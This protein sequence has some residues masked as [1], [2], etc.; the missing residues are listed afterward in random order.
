M[1]LGAKAFFVTPSDSLAILADRLS[2]IPYFERSGIKGIARSMP[3]A[4]SVDRY[5][6]ISKQRVQIRTNIL[7]CATYLIIRQ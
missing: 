3:T 2:I 5:V 1:I 7:S 4:A 6:K